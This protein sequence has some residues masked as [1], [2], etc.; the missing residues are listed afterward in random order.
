VQVPLKKKREFHD[1]QGTKHKGLVGIYESLLR[2]FKTLMLLATMLPVY[3]LGIL[4]LGIALTPG[5][6]LYTFVSDLSVQWPLAGRAFS[7]GLCFAAGYFLYGTTLVLIVP[8]FNRLLAWNIEPFRGAFYSKEA[9]RWGIHNALV[10]VVRFTFLEFITPSP[11]NLLFYRMMG[12]KIGDGVHINTSLISDPCLITLEDKVTIGGS[13]TII[14]HYGMGGFLILSPVVIRK[15]A[16]VGLKASILG[17]VEI[18]EGS[19]VMANSVVLPNTK[20][21]A[22]EVWGG[23]PAKKIEKET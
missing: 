23:V 5:I 17:G 12:M 8:I 6:M 22:G 14:A 20:I 19:V 3:F 4:I 15:G 16:T 13:A 11:F 21:P 18:G 10:Y 1:P 2:R 9:I 7:L